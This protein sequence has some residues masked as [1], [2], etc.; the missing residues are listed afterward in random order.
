MFFEMVRSENLRGVRPAKNGNF[1]LHPHALRVNCAEIHS[2]K[3]MRIVSALAAS[4][5]LFCNS[6]L[7]SA[8]TNAPDASSSPTEEKTPH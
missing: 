8:E 5:L 2:M 7:Y 4:A 3:I 6:P 1:D